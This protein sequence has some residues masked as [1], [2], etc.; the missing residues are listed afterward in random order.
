M[1]ALFVAVFFLFTFSPKLDTKHFLYKVVCVCVI[2]GNLCVLDH[3]STF[4]ALPSFIT[5]TATAVDI[6]FMHPN[7]KLVSNTRDDV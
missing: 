2:L 6:W 4:S 7:P 1:I 5:A 3:F